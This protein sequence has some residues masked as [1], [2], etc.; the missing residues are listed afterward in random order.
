MHH[1]TWLGAQ[2]AQ[3][4]LPA[5]GG[6]LHQHGAHGGGLQPHLV[7]I[8]ADRAAAIGHHHVAENRIAENL[9]LDRRIGG[10]HPRPVGVH[11]FGKHHGQAGQ[12]ALPH[13]G[14]RNGEHDGAVRADGDPGAECSR[15]SRP[16]PAPPAARTTRPECSRRKS[17]RQRLRESRAATM[18]RSDCVRSCPDLLPMAHAPCLAARSTARRMRG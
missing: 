11:L 15:S 5:I 18:C 3:R 13:F 14:D 17:V 4:H 6:R 12:A 7:P 1:E 8:A 9:R 10:R 2:F 16:R